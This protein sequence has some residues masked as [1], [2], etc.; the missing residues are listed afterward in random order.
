MGIHNSL[1]L[2]RHPHTS[3]ASPDEVHRLA[4]PA[5]TRCLHQSLPTAPTC[6][7]AP[8]K[9][10]SRYQGLGGLPKATSRP[11]ICALPL[12]MASGLALHTQTTHA[13]LPRQTTLQRMSIQQSYLLHLRVRSRKAGSAALTQI[14]SLGA[15]PKKHSVD[16]FYDG[17]SC[18][19]CSLT[20]MKVDQVV[21][22]VLSLEKGALLAKIDIESAFRNIP[23]HPDD[24]HLLGMRWNDGLFIDTVLPFRG[25][26]LALWRYK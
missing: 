26:N 12:H 18:Q 1:Y 7:P 19:L 2:L 3:R 20:Y 23:A 14:S 15:I 10:P 8:D 4:R 25:V 5:S 9:H 21:Q 22:Q 17:I 13:T 16:L 6:C 11:G 24:R